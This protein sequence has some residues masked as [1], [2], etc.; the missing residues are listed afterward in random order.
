MGTVKFPQTFQTAL[1]AVSGLIYN[2]RTLAV[3]NLHGDLGNPPI[4]GI[5]Y[6]NSKTAGGRFEAGGNDCGGGR[7]D[8][9][10]RSAEEALCGHGRDR[11]PVETPVRRVFL[12]RLTS[13]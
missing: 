7:K 3:Y 9:G 5:R 11:A 1:L 4:R 12:P 6:A 8:R 2:R 10:G 13:A